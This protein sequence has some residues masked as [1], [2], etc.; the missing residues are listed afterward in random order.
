[1]RWSAEHRRSLD[2]M[3]L[4]TLRRVTG[5]LSL[6]V[7]TSLCLGVPAGFFAVGHHYES[8]FLKEGVHRAAAA[9]T[10]FTYLNQDLW[11]LQESRLRE[12]LAPNASRFTELLR[13]DEV[14]LAAAG[15]KFD[16]PRITQ[17]QEVWDGDD[18][19]AL[20]RAS[21]SLKPLLYNT[22]LVALAAAVVALLAHMGLRR[23]PF[24]ALEHAWELLQSARADVEREVGAKTAALRQLE[25]S[26]EVLRQMALHDSLTG[27]ANRL[28]FT[29]RL[30]QALASARRTGGLVACL[31]IDLDNFKEVNDELGHEVGDELLQTVVRR[32][33]D[34]LRE[35][36]SVARL[37]GDEFAIVA[38]CRSIE[39]A[40]TLAQ[41]VLAV[42]N[43]S[44]AA[45]EHTLLPLA[46]IGVA[47]YPRHGDDP[48]SVLRCADVAMY[49]AKRR[50]NTYA[51]YDSDIARQRWTHGKPMTATVSAVQ[52]H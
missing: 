16:G 3:S 7:A 49:A 48:A 36:D 11:W 17:S 51:I 18:V 9:V 22:A 38:T 14:V 42:L 28:L 45:N 8:R 27:A 24:R 50:G 40:E 34:S 6:V 10:R 52:S 19:V 30:D 43:R 32:L 35:S 31:V 47:I 5:A 13:P 41:K 23:V 33:R 12:L 1:M 21:R 39:D 46:S 2:E 26:Q 44:H 4:R 20:V 29:E 15:E 25:E 37:G